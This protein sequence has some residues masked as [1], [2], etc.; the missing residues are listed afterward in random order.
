MNLLRRYKRAS[1]SC[2]CF[3]FLSV[4]CIAQDT[5]L[6]NYF[7][8][9]GG[10]NMLKR[11]DLIF[12]P[13]IHNDIS[14]LNTEIRY[15]H[16]RR[17]RQDIVISFS[18]FQSSITGAYDY[19][20]DG[21]TLTQFP[22][23]FNLIDINY[24]L[25]KKIM[26]KERLTLYAGGSFANNIDVMNYYYGF[27][28]YFGYFATF[29]LSGMAQVTYKINENSKIHA[30]VS[31]PLVSQVARSPYLI[32]DDEFIQNNYSHNGVKTFFAY[33]ADGNME[34]LNHFQKLTAEIT[35][36]TQLSERWEAGV[37]YSFDFSHY[38]P[39]AS[40]TSVEN[41]INILIKYN[42]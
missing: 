7:S 18:S 17:L 28:S 13:F 42:F 1:L 31:V 9:Q 22:H 5:S 39:V 37:Q 26:E 8:L 30:G 4:H 14:F 29:S 35:Y 38:S 6:H 12:S 25:S 11:Q 20:S 15:G 23:A 24:S 10:M 2:I 40:F 27:A 19:Y 33:L 16:E 34:T 36:S 32:N 21:D 41:K 3:I